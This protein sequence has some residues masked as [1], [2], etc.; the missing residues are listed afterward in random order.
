MIQ[1]H[2]IGGKFCPF[3][4][5]DQCGEKIENY[6]Q[7]N[8]T[9]D[10]ADISGPDEESIL[11][12]HVHKGTCDGR[13]DRYW[14][15]LEEHLLSLVYNSGLQSCRFQAVMRETCAERRKP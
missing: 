15:P 5:C 7:A 6:K 9:F 12:R 8:A 14:V 2:Y 11:V 13:R 10:M 1:I 3:L 4:H